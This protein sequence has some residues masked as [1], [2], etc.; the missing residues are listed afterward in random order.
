MATGTPPHT[1]LG[2]RRDPLQ[3]ANAALQRPRELEHPTARIGDYQFDHKLGQGTFGIVY[4]GVCRRY[5]KLVAIKH[6]LFR[7]Q[8]KSLSITTLREIAVLKVLKHENIVELLDVISDNI[9]DYLANH[10]PN[11]H[12]YRLPDVL[13]MVFPYMSY[14]LT[15]ILQN[16]DISLTEEDRKSIMFQLFQGI[17]YIHQQKY[18]HRDIKASNIL[19][20][21]NGLLK[22]GD[23]GLVRRYSG[24][25]PSLDKHGGGATPLTEV[26]MTRWYRAPEVLFGNRRYGTAVDIWG[27]GCV[28]GELYE[29]VPI[30]KGETDIDQGIKIFDLCG[31]PSDTMVNFDRWKTNN[32]VHPQKISKQGNLKERFSKSMSKEGVDLLKGLLE[33]DPNN[34]LTT[35]KALDL[36][37]FHNDPKPSARVKTNFPECHEADAIRQSQLEKTK[38]RSQPNSN[39]ATVTN[40][41]NIPNPVHVNQPAPL[42]V[43]PVP[44]AGLPQLPPQQR[45][46]QPLYQDKQQRQPSVPYPIQHPPAGPVPKVRSN[47][48]NQAI[49]N[50]YV[51]KQRADYQ[52]NPHQRYNNSFEQNQRQGYPPNRQY[53]SNK[54]YPRNDQGYFNS[55]QKPNRPNKNFISD[56]NQQSVSYD[57]PTHRSNYNN[58][59]R[60]HRNNQNPVIQNPN[61]TD[62]PPNPRYQRQNATVPKDDSQY[63]SNNPE[64]YNNQNRNHNNFPRKQHNQYPNPRNGDVSG[65]PPRN[66]NIAGGDE[67]RDYNND[68][69]KP[70]RQG[71]A[72][73]DESKDNQNHLSYEGRNARLKRDGAHDSHVDKKPRLEY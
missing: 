40:N 9:N 58:Y 66:N 3:A 53:D 23:F 72:Y 21:Q 28:L 16:K 48:T 8:D 22:I 29:K 36:D 12:L 57:S 60:Q 15:G 63:P 7:I 26:V 64:Y 67:A 19:I 5:N 43:L 62:L 42:P 73:R 37:W 4:K 25:P 32:S 71:G 54:S 10:V 33:V 30:L 69:Q 68:S 52:Q 2:R 1:A 24:E 6:V 44:P 38:V 46:G 11:K 27:I 39:T 17:D 56:S 70:D 61:Y 20:N 51:N 34:R 31:S 35:A 65:P 14:D 50:T 41:Y 47:V 59:P 13:C 18:L 55:N 49:P 45:P